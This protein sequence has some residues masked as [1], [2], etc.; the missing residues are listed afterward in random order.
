[1]QE[2]QIGIGPTYNLT[3]DISIYGGA[4]AFFHVT[5]GQLTSQGRAPVITVPEV[6]PR[7]DNS[8]RI[9]EVSVLG[10]YIGSEIR[11]TETLSYS[12]EYQY[13][14]PANALGM[15]LVWRF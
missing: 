8:Y 12:I 13:T 14:E 1:M 2:M 10:G 5:D 9:D 7:L 4:S 15:S 3:R 6:Y 11:I